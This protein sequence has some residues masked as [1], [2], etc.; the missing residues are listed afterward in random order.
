[1]GEFY[2]IT[3]NFDVVK[4]CQGYIYFTLTPTATGKHNNDPQF[5]FL[6]GD[7]YFSTCVHF[8]KPNLQTWL[9]LSTF[10]QLLINMQN[11]DR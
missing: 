10:E 2:E 4:I 9:F 1:M 7:C 11:R 6:T 3:L 8:R 5:D